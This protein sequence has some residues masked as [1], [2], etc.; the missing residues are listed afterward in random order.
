[1][2]AHDFLR[3][4]QPTEA[5]AA[6]QQEIRANPADA[7][8]RVFLFQLLAVEGQWERAQTQLSVVKDMDAAAVPMA[9]AYREAIRCELLRQ[10]IFA[11]KRQPLVF[12]E[13]QQWIALLLESLKR[14]A[15]GEHEPAQRL[16][17]Q[18]FE[19]APTTAGTLLRR[20]A[21]EAPPPDPQ[22]FAWIA[23]ADVRLGPVMEAIIE[24]R[25]YWVPWQHIQRVVIDPPEDLRDVVW[26]P[27]HFVWTNG[28]DTVALLPARYPLSETSRDPAIRLSRKTEWQEV[29]PDVYC[30]SGQKMLATDAGEF[31][32]M[33]VAEI[34]LGG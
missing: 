4:G 17:D 20:A 24:G 31:A 13:P 26:M 10:Q 29:A 28:G 32:L 11:G 34:T 27:A 15:A 1:M 12:G 19:E 2:S 16:R 33:D 5:L 6:L 23:D 9:Q 22:P 8:L 21:P 30:G 14:L 3:E 7:K 18:A 25:Y